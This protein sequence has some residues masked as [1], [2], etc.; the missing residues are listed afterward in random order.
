[1][2]EFIK[3]QSWALLTNKSSTTFLLKGRLFLTNQHLIF[4]ASPFSLSSTYIS[5][6]LTDINAM[7]PVWYFINSL[8]ITTKQGEQLI[9]GVIDR[10]AIQN[11]IHVQ[12]TSDNAQ[13]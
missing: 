12:L 6:A 1:M 9:F 5:I 2:T 11:A 10:Q 8:Q 3:A 13:K 7:E 4:R